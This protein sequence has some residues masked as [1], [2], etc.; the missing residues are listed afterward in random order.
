MKNLF[1]YI[2]IFLFALPAN[3]QYFT[4]TQINT[5][6]NSK[7]ANE[8]DM[9]LDTINNQ[10]FI[11]LSNGS[12]AKIGDTIDETIDTILLIGDSV[13]FVE[14][15]D[16]VYSSILKDNDWYKQGTNSS[17]QNINDSI[18]TNGDIQLANYPET[19]A[20]DTTAHLN[21]LYTDNAGNVKSARRE[22][23]PPPV[24]LDVSSTS[25]GN[26]FN[27]YNHYATQLTNVGLT[28][29]PLANLDFYLMYYDNAVFN[30][31]SVSATGVLTYDVISTSPNQNRSIYVVFYTK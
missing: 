13:A 28:P 20:D 16:T 5:I 31:V 25:T 23:I 6:R 26:T 1:V 29:V 24:D 10:F 2:I 19:R 15:L 21:M 4:N 11:G 7:T 8:G 22:I 17:P 27:Y 12:L 14:G 3:S 30:N 18:Y 9:Y